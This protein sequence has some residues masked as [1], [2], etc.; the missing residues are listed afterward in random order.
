MKAER[1]EG[2]R[3]RSESPR[4]REKTIEQKLCAA[5][6]K[7]GGIAMKL[8]S[9]GLAGVPDRLLLF[10]GGRIAFCELKA[11]GQ[12][13]RPLQEHRIAQ[14]RELGFRV[15]IVDSVE[16]IPLVLAAKAEGVQGTIGKPFGVFHVPARGVFSRAAEG[17]QGAIGKP[18]GIPKQQG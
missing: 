3:G 13:P 17:V 16:A 14:L 1:A 8:V 6:R 11:P 15:F 12:K 7:S 18:P 5:V 9:P 10:P 4:V 2:V